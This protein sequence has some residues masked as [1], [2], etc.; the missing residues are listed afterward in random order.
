MSIDQVKEEISKNI[1]R[2]VKITVY[3]MRNRVSKYVGTINEVYPNVFTVLCDGENKSFTYVDVITKEL[4]I[5]Y[6]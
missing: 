5:E 2:K 3:G 1:N 6:Y 4:E